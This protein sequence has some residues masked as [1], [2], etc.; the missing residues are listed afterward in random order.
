M[1]VNLIY[2]QTG[3]SF[4]I[5]QFTALSF[6]YEVTNKVFRIPI[7]SFK[8]FYKEQYIPNTQSQVSDY[9]KKF[10]IIINVLENKKPNHQ[11]EKSKTNEEKL[12][13]E[14]FS[15]SSSDKQKQKKKIL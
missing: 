12:L 13:N 5:T 6:I 3:Y 1:N 8:L 10:P 14:T 15:L 7:G 4:Q 11:N 2:K 9:F